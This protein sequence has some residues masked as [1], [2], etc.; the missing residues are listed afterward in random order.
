M[1][2]F[3]QTILGRAPDAAG[4][5]FWTAEATRVVGLGADVK[6][7]FYAMAMQFFASTEYAARNTNDTQY[8]TDLYVTFFAR[9]PDASGLA[10]WQGEL[11]AAQSRS[12]LLNSFLFSTEFSNLMTSLFGT[13][14]VRPEVNMTMDLFRGTFGRL[15]DSDG[16]NCWLG[17]IRQRAVPGGIAGLE[18]LN[19]MLG[20][21]STAAK[22]VGPLRARPRLHGRR[23]QRLHAARSW[24]R[25]GRFNFWVGQVPTAGRDGVRSQFVP[26]AEF[27][28]RV[29]AIVDGGVPRS[30][31]DAKVC[32][33]SREH[34]GT[35]SH[36]AQGNPRR[37]HA[38]LA[39]VT[40]GRGAEEDAEGI[41]VRPEGDFA[42][43]K[44]LAPLFP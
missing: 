5:D 27:Q 1:T 13:T 15:P 36:L 31:P 4:L 19:T 2:S 34:V 24:R 28:A 7:V 30:Q 8:L 43:R 29:A 39:C 42:D 11:T 41:A 33:L 18:T 16:F 22:Y 26:S 40:D 14:N 10:Y 21:S 44:D 3:Y 20:P 17:V 38:R 9:D 6:E 12:A 23:L 37:G 35:G 25:H 32:A